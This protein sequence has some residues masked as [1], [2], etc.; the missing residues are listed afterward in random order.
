MKTIILITAVLNALSENV[1]N[2]MPGV[3][4]RELIPPT[5]IFLY[6]ENK[7]S[8]REDVSTRI[9]PRVLSYEQSPEP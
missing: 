1:L 2:C 7:R 4:A 3:E 8:L 5:K 6:E 9:L